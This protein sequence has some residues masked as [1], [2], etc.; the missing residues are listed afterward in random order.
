MDPQTLNNI[1]FLKFNKF[2]W[3]DKSIFDEIS[4][5]TDEPQNDN[6]EKIDEQN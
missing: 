4:N 6:E 3:E 1:L 5:Q 2:L